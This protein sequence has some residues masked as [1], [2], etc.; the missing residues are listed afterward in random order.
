MLGGAS[1]AWAAT[2]DVI[3]GRGTAAEEAKASTYEERL[4]E[5]R[6]AFL[7][8]QFAQAK[9]IFETFIADYGANDQVTEVVAAVRPLLALCLVRTGDFPE[10][11]QAVDDALVLPGLARPLREELAFARGIIAMQ[12][13]DWE[14]AQT[15]FGEFYKERK[16]SQWRRDEALILF[17]TSQMRAGAHAEAA[18]FFASQRDQLY[19]TNPA[20]AGRV[21]VLELQAR[22]TA[23]D[24]AGAL[25]LIK[26]AF[27]R[28]AEM[29]QLVAFQNSV[30]RLGVDFF[31]QGNYY[32][33]VSCLQ[34][35]WPR[36]RLLQHQQE[37]IGVLE[38]RIT[39]LQERRTQRDAL[40]AARASLARA[41]AS[42]AALEKQASFDAAVR[43]RLARS[44]AELTRFRE[45]ALI[46]EGMLNE[47][48]ADA[49]V[50]QAAVALV[51]SWMQIGRWPRAI[52]S[53]KAYE[54]KF[55]GTGLE[56][57]IDKVRFLV[58][59]SYERDF[60]LEEALA[61]YDALAD[62]AK[63][64]S[65]AARAAF[66]SGTILLGL[67][68]NKDA[69]RS[70][71]TFRAT[72][73]KHALVEDATYW[74]AMGHSFAKAHDESFAAAG[75]YLQKYSQGKYLAEA[76]FRQAF[77]QHANSHYSKAITSFESFINTYPDTKHADEARLLMGDGLLAEGEI[78]SGLAA[79][80]S[81]APTST[82]F[83]EDAT[84]KTG[85]ALWL[86]ERYDDFHTHFTTFIE[87]H[88][89][90]GKI[91]EA[92]YQLGKL[93]L[94]QEDPAGAREAYWKTI[95]DLGNNPDAR[96]IEDILTA[97]P[98]TYKTENNPTLALTRDL[99][100]LIAQA[101]ASHHRT[102]HVRALW[103][104][105]TILE[106]RNPTLASIALLEAG[107]LA[108]PKFDSPRILVDC[109]DARLASGNP[110][111]ATNLYHEAKRWNPRTPHKDRIYLG[112]AR[113]SEIKA[114]LVA[115]TSYYKKC[116]QET[117]RPP[118][119]GEALLTL[120][121]LQSE[122]TPHLARTTLDDLLADK[123]IP[124]NHKAQ[125]LMCYAEILIAEGEEKKALAY[126]ERIYVAY[127]KYHHLVATAYLKRGTLLETL[128]MPEK[129]KAVFTECITRE[130]LTDLPEVIQ[131]KAR[132]QALEKSGA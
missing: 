78:D 60:R 72:Y 102:L 41:K 81:I 107:S 47:M 98:R 29:E 124:T 90:S 120:A 14:N 53:G 101:K 61:A 109:A 121:K 99:D 108:D 62:S 28:M 49:I 122:K 42:I 24:Q 6:K 44:Y 89:S 110:K 38:N 74:E 1:A 34:R 130:D 129:A 115:A 114:D 82:R 73:P 11:K 117:F 83:Y 70:F 10:A 58:A 75:R 116:A 31:D 97:L 45:A 95:R 65:F 32:Q 33:A 123:T 17:G 50:E 15:A 93:S 5:G 30:V 68:R 86:T 37:M 96:G 3:K 87:K 94:K 80:K 56:K 132:L 12:L 43:L 16:H 35:V 39:A 67:D 100:A 104:K 126:F 9:M 27:P 64:K 113:A 111:T 128:G 76:T 131:A 26:A 71:K 118:L 51:E 57:G 112:L 25:A 36:K 79:Y 69:I 13:S 7:R 59:E 125:A 105:G 88:P 77:S 63:D 127:G 22:T 85:K 2:G 103:A 54:T 20:A 4:E 46:L 106:N 84:I 40:P 66:M 8:G 23:G 92:V 18:Q 21:A 52:E 119:R 55:S 91:A 48:P 19:E